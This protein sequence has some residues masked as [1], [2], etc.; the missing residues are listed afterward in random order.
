MKNIIF[1]NQIPDFDYYDLNTDSHISWRRH[2]Q[3]IALL[4]ANGAP[5]TDSTLLLSLGHICR[6]HHRKFPD[7]I[8]LCLV[9][10]LQLIHRSKNAADYRLVRRLHHLFHI[11][12]RRIDA[13]KTRILRVIRPIYLIK[14]FIGIFCGIRRKYLRKDLLK[15]QP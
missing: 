3:R 9:R 15:W 5:R 13:D 14:Y 7:R 1:A 10:A 11:L 12:Q 2:R 4:R 6:K 8:V